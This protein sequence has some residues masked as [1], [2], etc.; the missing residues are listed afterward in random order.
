MNERARTRCDPPQARP[1]MPRD[2]DNDNASSRGRRAGP[3]G[4]KGRSGA[5]RGPDKTIAKRGV[6]AK[7]FG[8]RGDDRRHEERRPYAGK[9]DGARSYGKKPYSGAGK[10]YG[11]GREGRPPRRDGD[12]PRPRGD[13]PS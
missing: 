1:L 5:K 9:S 13:R 11:G 6:G 2:N 10:P 7:E 4:G 8:K 3:P 12:A